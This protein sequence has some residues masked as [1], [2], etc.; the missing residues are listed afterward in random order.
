MIDKASWIINKTA[1]IFLLNKVAK[2]LVSIITCIVVEVIQFVQL[3]WSVLRLII[4][5][6]FVASDV[7][8]KVVA[9][10]ARTCF[11]D[12]VYSRIAFAFELLLR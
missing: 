2:C 1:R 9:Y 5:W 11:L 12:S 6:L 8:I 3:V 4:L 10:F 7:N